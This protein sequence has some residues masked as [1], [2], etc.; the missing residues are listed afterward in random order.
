MVRWFAG[1]GGA[2]AARRATPT[3]PPRVVQAAENAD[4]QDEI[5]GEFAS[6]KIPLLRVIN[7]SPRRAGTEPDPAVAAAYR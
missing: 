2:R 7:P 6:V 4:N 3:A 1:A 5:D